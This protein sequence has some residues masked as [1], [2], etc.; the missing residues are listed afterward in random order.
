VQGHIIQSTLLR[1]QPNFKSLINCESL[2]FPRSV[3]WHPRQ[4][5]DTRDILARM[6]PDYE[7]VGRVGRLPRSAWTLLPDWSAGGLLRCIVLPV[8]PCV[9]SFSKFHEP[10]THNLLRTSLRGCHED[11]TREPSPWNFSFSSLDYR[12][13]AT[14]N[15]EMELLQ[16]LV[17][18]VV[19]VTAAS[20][21][22][23]VLEDEESVSGRDEEDN[24]KS[25]SGTMIFTKLSEQNNRVRWL[26]S[27][28]FWSLEDIRLGVSG[29]GF[30]E[31]IGDARV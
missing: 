9:V 26:T 3:S 25:A 22:L 18:I 28:K 31:C 5:A 30:R 2:Q 1:R 27:L 17:L 21:S 20:R 24:E 14:D 19:M 4:H 12:Q 16:R 13:Q 6:L 15:D 29:F 10:D 8:C 23:A 11:T 7:D